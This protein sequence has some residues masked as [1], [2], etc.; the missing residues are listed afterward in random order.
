[1]IV[2]I[3]FGKGFLDHDD[4]NVCLYR[5]F[6]SFYERPGVPEI[7]QDLEEKQNVEITVDSLRLAEN[8]EELCRKLL[9]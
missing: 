2:K 1:M 3:F 5:H 7:I 8:P 4:F 9:D 6:K